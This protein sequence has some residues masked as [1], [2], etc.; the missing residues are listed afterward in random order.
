M[1]SIGGVSISVGFIGTEG[2]FELES[3][4]EELEDLATEYPWLKERVS[5]IQNRLAVAASSI[6][7]VDE[8]H[9]QEQSSP[10]SD[11]S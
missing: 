9:R 6:G 11:S 2:Y 10:H 8:H 1:S 4:I 7:M 5:L 3:A